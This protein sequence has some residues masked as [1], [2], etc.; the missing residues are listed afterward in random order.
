MININK[1]MVQIFVSILIW[2]LLC[3]IVPYIGY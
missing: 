3:F 1:E 2:Y